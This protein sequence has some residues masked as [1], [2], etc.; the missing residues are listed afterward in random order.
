MQ[1]Q[2]FNNPKLY[3]EKVKTYLLQEEAVHCMILGISNSLINYPDHHEAQPY[4]V[5]IEDDCRIIATA[6]KTHPRKLIL[7][8]SLQSEAIAKIAEDLAAKDKSLSGVIA[9]KSEATTF[10]Q[11]WHSLTGNSYQQTLAL[12]V[13]QLEAVSSFKQVSGYLRQAKTS[14]RNLLTNWIQNFRLEAL[15]ENGS[16]L[17]SDRWFDL[18][19]KQGSLYVWQNNI[20]VSMVAYGGV[21]PNGI[22]INAVYTP[23]EYRGQGYATSCVAVMSQKLLD[24]GYKYC[25]LYTDLSNSTSNNIYRQLGYKPICD[26]SDYSFSV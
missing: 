4:L 20:V 10:A 15:G 3:Y 9:P 23:P 26:I 7:S 6:V 14:D 8:C 24:R 11:T 5:A 17:D 18:R 19:L 13:H 21:T 16:K 1:I 12:R 22:R 2:Q 25:F